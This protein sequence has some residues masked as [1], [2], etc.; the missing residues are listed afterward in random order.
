MFPED[1]HLRKYLRPSGGSAY[2]PPIHKRVYPT[3][4]SRRRGEV[5]AR[6]ESA[7]IQHVLENQRE[8]STEL[9]TLLSNQYRILRALGVRNIK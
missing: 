4:S 8:M 6:G 1:E 9:D 7:G 2:P 5:E 3:L